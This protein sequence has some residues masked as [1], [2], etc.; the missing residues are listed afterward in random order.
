MLMSRA[1]GSGGMSELLFCSRNGSKDF[2]G[3]ISEASYM[4]LS[5]LLSQ[6]LNPGVWEFLVTP[7]QMPEPDGVQGLWSPVSS[8]P[9]SHYTNAFS[10]LSLRHH[11][12]QYHACAH[13]ICRQ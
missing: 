6:G 4:P 1:P 3:N 13:V 7:Q 2:C 9:L 10:T 8:L 12:R 11:G 5:Q